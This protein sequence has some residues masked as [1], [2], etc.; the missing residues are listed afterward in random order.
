MIENLLCNLPMSQLLIKKK[1]LFH[2][3]NN[4]I[5][6]LFM[7]RLNYNILLSLQRNFHVIEFGQ[8]DSFLSVRPIGG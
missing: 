4:R 8:L 1:Q 5:V 2:P 7:K 6:V 3:K